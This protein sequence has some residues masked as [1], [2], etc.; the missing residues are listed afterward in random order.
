MKELRR[1]FEIE[2]QE[3]STVEDFIASAVIL[4]VIV[5]CIYLVGVT[6]LVVNA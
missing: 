2:E 5:A 6:I 4:L 3:T 1:F